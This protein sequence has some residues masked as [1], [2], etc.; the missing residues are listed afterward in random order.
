MTEITHYGKDKPYDGPEDNLQIATATWLKTQH[1]TLVAFHVPNGGKRPQ[2]TLSRKGK[3]YVA[4]FAGAKLKKMGTLAGV[5]DWIILRPC[6][7][8]PGA[9]IELKTKGGTLQDTQTEFLTRAA[10]AGYYTS[11]AWSFEGFQEAINYYLSLPTFN[12]LSASKAKQI[13]NNDDRTPP[14]LTATSL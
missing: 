3:V 4:N 12:E 10:A 13:H 8:Y 14:F 1:P 11:V 6:C 2:T 9:V 5:S 7:L